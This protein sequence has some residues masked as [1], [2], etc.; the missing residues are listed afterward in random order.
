MPDIPPNPSPADPP[1]VTPEERSTARQ[2]PPPVLRTARLTLRAAGEADVP[3]LVAAMGRREIAATTASI[4]H[5]FSEADARTFLARQPARWTEGRGVDFGIF[6]SAEGA[7]VGGIGVG[8]RTDSP[9][10]AGSGELGY[11]IA[12]DHWGNGFAT[13]AVAA[14][15]D[16]ALQTLGLD[17]LGARHFSN[18]P[19]S[20]QV[21]RKAG[22]L[23][24]GRRRG[25]I[26]KDGRRHDELFYGLPRRL[27]EARRAAAQRPPEPDGAPIALAAYEALAEA[28]SRQAPTKPHNAEYDRPAVLSLVGDVAGKLILD[29]GCGPGIY[30]EELLRRGA[31]RVVGLDV[32]PAM[33]R[34]ARQRLADH[35]G[36]RALLI[37][38]NLE[39][40]L[41]MLAGE[42]FDLVVCPLVLDYV[43]DWTK[44][45]REFRRV[46]RPGGT[47]VFSCEHPNAYWE[48]R[49][50]RDYFALERRAIFWSG[51]G[52]KPVLMP[53]Y[54]RPLQAA[55]NA[56]IDGGLRID[57]VLEPQPTA[58]F[59][60][61]DPMHCE[62]IAREPGFLCV[63][64]VRLDGAEGSGSCRGH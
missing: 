9:V 54:R 4:P 1:A 11:W 26:L 7:L 14:V 23:W 40:G 8:V 25:S 36:G 55:L 58:A 59:R 62:E 34:Q 28:Y 18:N 12:V 24:E 30:A 53:S 33:L 64:A 46:L 32:S 39:R 42:S 15:A 45:M 6:R 51:F 16:F 10:D 47:L 21:L 22:F 44:L 20:G 13:E 60:A 63:R 19:A 27:W 52:D 2:W 5:P 41:P 56:V 31:A 37:E 61:M 43:H 17:F 35:L 50:P 57:R 48:Q 49:F 29:A 3:A 38:A